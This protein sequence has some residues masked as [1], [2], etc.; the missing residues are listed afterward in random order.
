MDKTNAQRSQLRAHEGLIAET[1]VPMDA[2]ASDPSRGG[3]A[4]YPLWY[5]LS[6]LQ[7]IAQ[8]G[9]DQAVQELQPCRKTLV[10]WMARI[11]PYEQRGGLPRKLIGRDQL[12]LAIYITAYPDAE[13]EECAAYKLNNG[14][15]LYSVSTICRRMQEFRLMRKK[16]SVEAFQAFLPRNILRRDQF[17][18]MPPPLGVNGIQ[19]RRLID[20]NECALS[21]EP[22]TNRKTAGRS[23]TTT[24]RLRKPGHYPKGK[25]LMVIFFLEPGDPSLHPNQDGS[26]QN[27]RRWFYTY[28][29]GGT[30]STIFSEKVDLVLQSLEASNRPVDQ[31]RVFLWDNLRSH[32][33]NQVCQTVYARP[34]PNWF[35]FVARPPYMPKYGPSEY[36]FAELGYRL[37]QNCQD[38]W[39]YATLRQEVNQILGPT[40]GRGGSFD[41]LF[42]HC[43]Y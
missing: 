34:S 13:I 30:N 39:T 9:L 28:E 18:G 42:Q 26:I 36:A 3:S 20:V 41:A 6:C 23:H 31:H 32:L 40:I 43:G 11:R 15:G 21:I 19:R 5:R 12:L 2:F 27:P 7:K 4:G 38:D 35:A 22:T 8:V 1:Q 37:R 24:I 25:K 16:V 17:F 33:T 14:G 10:T 29:D